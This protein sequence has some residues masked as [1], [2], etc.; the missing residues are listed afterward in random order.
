MKHHKCLLWKQRILA[1]P[2]KQVLTQQNSS[3]QNKVQWAQGQALRD[4]TEHVDYFTGGTATCWIKL[5]NNLSQLKLCQRHKPRVWSLSSRALWSAVSYS[6]QR[7]VHQGWLTSEKR[8][9]EKERKKKRLTG[10]DH[11]MALKAILTGT[12]TLSQNVLP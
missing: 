2:I 12:W 3:L 8:R 4:T 7:A 9:T 1:V 10:R 11:C 6:A 5:S